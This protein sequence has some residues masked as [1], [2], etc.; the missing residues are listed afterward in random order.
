MERAKH[1]DIREF[2]RPKVRPTEETWEVCIDLAKHYGTTPFQAFSRIV[3]IGV[4]VAEARKEGKPL[5]IKQ[6]N[7]FIELGSSGK[8]EKTS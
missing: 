6:G 3:K 5:Y 7:E 4:D 1:P 2:R 8:D